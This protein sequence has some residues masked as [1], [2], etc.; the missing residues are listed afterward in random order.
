[1]S[2]WRFGG[3]KCGRCA[4]EA[5]PGSFVRAG[6]VAGEARLQEDFVTTQAQQVGVA[7]SR[8]RNL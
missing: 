3:I 1:M 4:D 5:P 7:S 6:V 8:P 2:G